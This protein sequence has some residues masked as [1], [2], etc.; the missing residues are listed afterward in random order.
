MRAQFTK[1][2]PKLDYRR[3]HVALTFAGRDLLGSIVNVERDEVTGCY[4]ATVR[5]FCGDFWPIKPALS[6]LE[7]LE[8]TYE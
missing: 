4:R 7:I 8:V 2:G 1:H 5:Y 3:A 6:A